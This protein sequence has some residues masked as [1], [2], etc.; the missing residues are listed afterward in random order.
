MR[1]ELTKTSDEYRKV[2]ANFDEMMQD[3]Y[4]RIIRI[5]RIQNGPWYI[6]YLAYGAQLYMRLKKP[7]ERHLYHG[8][9][10]LA[11]LS[12]VKDCF[13]RSFAGVNG[14]FILFACVLIDFLCGCRY[15]V[16]CW[17]IFFFQCRL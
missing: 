15:N 10:E 7:T 17:C 12:I 1:V 8:C 5:E 2:L 9:P 16:W 14:E 4:T 11:A 3:K 6:Q 13:N